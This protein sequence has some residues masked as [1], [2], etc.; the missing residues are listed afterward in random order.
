MRLLPQLGQKPRPLHEN[1]SWVVLLGYA[2][3]ASFTMRVVQWIASVRAGKGV[4]PL[5]F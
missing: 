2:G 5:A 1:G 4:I 3:Q